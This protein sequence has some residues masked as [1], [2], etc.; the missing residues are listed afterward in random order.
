MRRHPFLI[1]FAVLLVVAPLLS[2]YIWKKAESHPI[3][4]L[5]VDKTVLEQNRQEHSPLFWILANAKYIKRDASTYSQDSDYFGFFPDGKGGY[6]IN[7]FDGY[8]DSALNVLSR[9][10]DMAYYTDLYGVY[11]GEW[12]ERYPNRQRHNPKMCSL[13]PS[14][15]IYG[16]MNMAEVNLLKKMKAQGKLIITEFNAVGTPTSIPVAHEFEKEFRMAWQGWVGRYYS[17]LDTNT[18]KELPRWI[19][20]NYTMQNGGKWPFKRSGIVLV[21]TDEKVVILE[22]ETHLKQDVP[23]IETTEKFRARYDLPRSIRFHYWFDIISASDSLDVLATYRID[24]NEE[25]QKVLDRNDIPKHF[26]AVV[27]AKSSRY[28]FY[29]FA[30]DFSDMNIS[31]GNA[32]Y[33][34]IA[35][36]NQAMIRVEGEGRHAFFWRFYRPLVGSIIDEYY[37]RR[38]K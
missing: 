1:L 26:P 25:G 20:R 2:R 35:A 34:G 14:E 22:K 17:S 18:N 27:K 3:N 37:T 23:L 4:V 19:K 28:G 5:V 12:Y 6:R 7:D 11:S 21:H 9:K 32:K 33:A 15:R 31:S 36:V 38:M 30:G 24:V 29:Y 8:S 10:Y 16:G 13:E